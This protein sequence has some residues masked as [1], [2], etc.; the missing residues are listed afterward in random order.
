MVRFAEVCRLIVAA[1]QVVCLAATLSG[2]VAIQLNHAG[3]PVCIL[4]VPHPIDLRSGRFACGARISVSARPH[5]LR[6]PAATMF[7]MRA[8]RD[9]RKRRS[10]VCRPPWQIHFIG[11]SS[12]EKI[13]QVLTMRSWACLGVSTGVDSISQLSIIKIVREVSC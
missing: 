2:L 1:V 13:E 9:R 5:K 4:R 10:L 8:L 11:D 7:P 6:P 12:C 3:T